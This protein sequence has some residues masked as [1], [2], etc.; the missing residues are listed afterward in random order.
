MENDIIRLETKIAYQ[1][2]T[3]SELDKIIQ[4]QQNDIDLLKKEIV[5]LNN[6]FDM[7]NGGATIKP[8]T[9]EERPPHY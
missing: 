5:L 4:K 2:N 1:D 8:F 7:A 9:E 3:I 6:K